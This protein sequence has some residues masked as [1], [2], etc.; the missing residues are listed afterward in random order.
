MLAQWYKEYQEKGSLDGYSENR[1]L[2][3]SHE[4]RQKAI[5]FYLNNG[6][7]IRRT[8]KALGYPGKSTLCDWLNEEVSN[9][10]RKW[11]C[12]ASKSLV[13]CTQ[14]QKEQAVKDYCAGVHTTIELGKIYGVDPYTIY[15]WKDKLLGQENKTVMPNMPKKTTS[16]KSAKCTKSDADVE[17]LLHDKDSLEKQVKELQQDIRRLKLEKDILQEAAKVIKKD[18]GINLSSLTNREKAI[19]INALRDRYFLKDLLKVLRMAKSSYCYQV[20]AMSND[21]YADLRI[22]VRAAF[23]EVNRRYGYRRIHSVIKTTGTIVSEKVIRRIMREEKLIVPNIQ[24]KKYNSYKGEI[25]PEVENIIER[26]FHANKPNARWLT[27]ITE[28]HIP[29]GKIYLSPIIDCFDGMPVSWT[30]GTAPDANLVNT[31]LDEA[32]SILDAD[33]KPILHS[34]RGC[35]YRWPGW[36]KR[37]EKAQ[38]TRSMSKKGCSPDNSACE[39]FFGRLKNEMFYGYS[40]AGVSLGQFIDQLD[41]YIKWYAEKRIKLSL[42]GMS[43]LDYRRSLGLA[44]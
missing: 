15:R 24:R 13:R 5:D 11:S 35:H 16:K 21:K 38:L 26:N 27:D 7:S 39:G 18:Q 40:W 31:M 44:V 3:Y 14:E 4:Q 32:I 30:I 34:D 42:G 19:I 41:K 1:H 33:E 6:R 28:F 2:K 23:N 25:S 36:I 29:A 20:T 8:I 43:P 37:M 10:K 17:S 9:D 12:K 22:H